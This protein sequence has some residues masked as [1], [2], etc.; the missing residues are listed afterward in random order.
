M[1][2]SKKKPLKAVGGLLVLLLA[3]IIFFFTYYQ[4]DEVQVM[5]SSHYSEKQIRK[6]VLR[7]PLASNSVLAPLLY[8][9]QN[10]KDV[11]FIE[12]Y[13][14]TRPDI[15]HRRNEQSALRGCDFPRADFQSRPDAGHA[16]AS[17]QTD[18]VRAAG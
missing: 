15:D 16:S 17:R 2:T 10:T 18:P 13:T 1:K 9:K 8:T 14:V 11:P 7:G 5:G 4:V 3:G 12:G 6:M